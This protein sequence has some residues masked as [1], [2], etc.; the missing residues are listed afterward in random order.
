[1]NFL[2][3]KEVAE[4]WDITDRQVRILCAAGK[5]VGAI[6][7][8]RAWLIPNDS[9]KP[10]DERTTRHKKQNSKALK[11]IFD[12]IDDKKTQLDDLRPLTT[13]EVERLKK[14]F[15]VEF[16][17]NTNAIEGNTLTL[18]ETAMVLEGITID[19]KP[20]KDHLEVIGH[21]DAFEYV[22]QLVQDK[23]P[24]SERIIKDIHS[25]VLMDKPQD[26][27]V[28]RSVPVHI[29]GA[30]HTPPQPY[31]VPVQMEQL[32]IKYCEMKH[33]IHLVERIATFHL[34]F[35]GVHPFIDGNGRTGRLLLNLELLQAGF[36]A[37][38]VKFSDRRRYYDCFNSYY[39][40]GNAEQ[41]INLVAEYI[42]EMLCRYLEML[43]R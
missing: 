15:L 28:Y 19:K 35:E 3:T 43:S 23:V 27:G 17:Y 31:L 2:T 7:K 41:M 18:Q 30:K 25:L 16:T 42:E 38:N 6:Q 9:E 26:K 21:K 1:M 10:V 13:G 5:V 34:L 22:L 36:P 39:E 33:N 4:K 12:R 40:T 20:L 24:L 32:I 8:G 37:I 11:S 14:D 29:M